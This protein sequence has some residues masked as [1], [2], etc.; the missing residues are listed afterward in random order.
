MVLEGLYVMQESCEGMQLCKLCTHS[1]FITDY[2]PFLY[3][4]LGAPINKQNANCRCF[5]CIYQY[6]D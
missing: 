4:R 2:F 1:Y 6:Q 3:A 5:V